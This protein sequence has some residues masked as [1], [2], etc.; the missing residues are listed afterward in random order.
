MVPNRGRVNL[1][2]GIF[3]PILAIDSFHRCS[4]QAPLAQEL[5]DDLLA[6]TGLWQGPWRLYAP[7]AG[8][9]NLRLSAEIRFTDQ[10][11]VTWHSPEWSE[12]SALS[13]FR[14]AREINYFNFI[15]SAPGQ[16]AW[17]TLCGYLARTTRHPTGGNARVESVSLAVKGAMIP[18]PEEA[19]VPAG[20]YL[21]FDPPQVDYTWKP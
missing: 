10:A 9:R 2:L 17:S 7:D 18:D 16:L 5:N 14:H 1:F 21:E 15:L 6:P 19:V 4:P 3:L 13:K 12:M 20:P 8:N 11:V